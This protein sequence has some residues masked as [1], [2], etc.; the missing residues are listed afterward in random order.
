MTKMIVNPIM[1]MHM[2]DALLSVRTAL[3]MLAVSAGLLLFASRKTSQNFDNFNVPLAG[4]MGA[5]VFAAQMINFAIPMT[6]SSGHIAGGILLA[7]M[8]GAYPAFVVLSCVLIVQAFFFADGGVLALGCNIFNMAFLS[9]LVAYPLVFLPIARRFESRAG[10]TV[11]AVAACVVS[12]QLGAFAVVLE[13]LC[14]DITE[15]P[16]AT[17][18]AF[19]LPIHL[20]IGLVEGVAT[21]AV[22]AL[23]KDARPSLF[24]GGAKTDFIPAR[25]VSFGFFLIAA[26]LA[27]AGFSQIAS[28]K[29]DGLEWSIAETSDSEIRTDS[30][31]HSLG[32]GVAE[33]TAILPDYSFADGESAA[34]TSVAGVVG[35]GLTALALLAF[36]RIIKT[37]R[38]NE[39]AG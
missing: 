15:L 11:A 39:R 17:F 33:K 24:A 3:I 36:S 27:G 29:P 14:S 12:L 30:P 18:A 8:L 32:K 6:G 20:P 10:L 34:G 16:F 19:M 22:L 28:E 37:A 21:A 7:A 1:A 31:A 35:G 13:T 26:L 4:V 25:K 9:C 2:A 5:F 38:R 23:L